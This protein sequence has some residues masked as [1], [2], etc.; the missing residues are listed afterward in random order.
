MSELDR[1][2]GC[3]C[4]SVRFTAHLRSPTFGA[5]HCGMCRKFAGGPFLAI[6]TAGV[7]W[8]QDADLRTYDSSAWAE[9]G[10]CGRCGSS[11]FYRIKGNGMTIVAFGALDDPRG[12]TLAREVF[13]DERPDAYCFAG[14][15]KGLTGA[16]LMAKAGG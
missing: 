15:L 3:L 13:I 2:G 9:R 4:G 10:F 14:D 11:L 1:D 7:D 12:L 5:C 8:H 16:E 6:G